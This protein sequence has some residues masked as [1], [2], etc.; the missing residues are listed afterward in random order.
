MLHHSLVLAYFVVVVLPAQFIAVT[1][2][3]YAELL[4]RLLKVYM[5]EVIV[6]MYL[7]LLPSILILYLSAVETYAHPVVIVVVVEFTLICGGLGGA[8]ISCFSTSFQLS[9]LCCHHSTE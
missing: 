7:Y 5:F 4:V 2:T 3:L 1:D 9:A 6:S 8:F